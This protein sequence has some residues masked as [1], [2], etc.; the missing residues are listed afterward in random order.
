MN[1]LILLLCLPNWGITLCAPDPA[2][3]KG[4]EPSTFLNAGQTIYQHTDT[5]GL[6]FGFVRYRLLLCR[7]KT[8]LDAQP[9]HLGVLRL[10]RHGHHTGST[11]FTITLLHLKTGR[12]RSL[13]SRPAWSTSKSRTAKATH[14]KLILKNKNNQ[15]FLFWKTSLTMQ[16]WLVSNSQRSSC[17][18]HAKPGK[19]PND[20]AR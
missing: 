14:R 13:S 17:L 9:S 12:L 16:P 5:P 10:S 7:P 3:Q 6:Y 19:V 18:Y 15:L 8:I 11:W 1:S 2:G 20:K 4:N